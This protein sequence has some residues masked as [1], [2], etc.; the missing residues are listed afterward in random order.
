MFLYKSNAFHAYETR[1]NPLKSRYFVYL[2]AIASLLGVLVFTEARAFKSEYVTDDFIAEEYGQADAIANLFLGRNSVD[3]TLT[4]VEIIALSSNKYRPISEDRK[5]T[6]RE[7][8]SLFEAKLPDLFN[9]ERAKTKQVSKHN[10]EI[11]PKTLSK[12][13]NEQIKAGKFPDQ[14]FC[15]GGDE[16]Y[17]AE[18]NG[19][20]REIG[21]QGVAN[22]LNPIGDI[23]ND[24][25]DDLLVSQYR[26][27][28]D[29][30]LNFENQDRFLQVPTI[31]IWN[32]QTKS[33]DSSFSGF[34][35]P[36]NR[37]L[38]DSLWIRHVEHADFDNDGFEDFILADA[39]TDFSP[40]CGYKN[41]LYRNIAGRDLEE[42]SLP[43]EVN[44][45]THAFSIGDID[46]DGDSDIAVV[47]SPYANNKIQKLCKSIYGRPTVNYSYFLENTGGMKFQPHTFNTDKDD[48]LFYSAR[49]HRLGSS[50]TT[51][52]IFGEAGEGWNNNEKSKVV[53]SQIKKSMG[54]KFSIKD[55]HYIY[56]PKYLGTGS[57]ATEFETFDITGDGKEELFISWQFMTPSFEL[58]EYNNLSNKVMGGQYIQVIQNPFSKSNKDIT[59]EVFHYP[60]PLNIRGLGSWCVEIYARDIDNDGDTDLMCSSFDQ[61][62]RINGDITPHPEPVPIFYRN[63]NGKLKGQFFENEVL[64]KNKWF[65]PVRHNDKN[66]M[67]QVEPF[68]CDEMYLE[69]SEIVN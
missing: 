61:W 46:G 40:E 10:L 19:S 17:K 14:E 50:K 49:I 15:G 34:E 69:V 29:E 65:I 24:G 60:Q 42:I 33:Y 13:A 7:L 25:F 4:E 52:M 47:N 12:Y 9:F 8:Y 30:Q 57:M 41:R 48:R 51:I 35:Y 28:M 21:N 38:S 6:R 32:E 62:R 45:Y 2:L 5:L 16:Y 31:L 56:P 59:E 63:E 1:R 18:V 53:I 36:I 11:D 67:A 3:G 37:K 55:S 27:Y 22:V 68:S 20:I 54:G 26:F 44:D 43:L 58:V 64:N 66:R 39:G 23:N